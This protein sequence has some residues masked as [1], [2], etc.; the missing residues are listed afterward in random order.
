MRVLSLLLLTIATPSLAVPLEINHQ[1]RLHDALGV[2]LDGSHDLTV[3]IYDTATGGS[4]AWTE[5]HTGVA[6]DNGY[7]TLQV[8][9]VSALDDTL[10]DGNTLYLSLQV[11]AGAEL[12]PRLPLVSVPY[13]IR[14]ETATVAD[15]AGS[16]SWSDV[17]GVPAG[18]DDGQ[19][20]D[21]LAE[22]VP[23][24]SDGEVATFAS[25]AWTCA[26]V[27]AADPNHALDADNIGSGIVNVSYLPIGTSAS[28]VA[29]G[30]HVHADYLPTANLGAAVD[31][32]LANNPVTLHAGTTVGG[33][34]IS[35]VG[36][37][38][39]PQTQSGNFT[40]SAS[41]D[42]AWFAITGDADVAL[43]D[44]AG[45]SAGFVVAFK[46]VSGSAIALNANSGQT[47]D[48]ATTLSLALPGSGLALITDGTDW[49][50]LFGSGDAYI[51]GQGWF[52]G[53][54]YTDSPG[55]YG[56]CPSTIT[57]DRMNDGVYGGANGWGSPQSG[58]GQYLQ[59]DLGTFRWISMIRLGGG[60]MPCWGNAHNYQNGREIQTSP[61][62]SNWTTLFAISGAQAGATDFNFA[63]VQ[64]RYVRL[65]TVA[66]SWAAT[67]EFRVGN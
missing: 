43:P 13:A 25:G 42:Y 40:V 5:Q 38:W 41:D 10:F 28:H 1:G 62:G 52:A 60:N 4:A 6:L 31:N 55:T 30:D 44:T 34:P 45:L 48:G 61:D 57:Y 20:N 35:D 33:T 21:T 11:D 49:Y 26:A 37:R 53:I 17:S 56:S 32:H 14:A 23:N 18:L 47:I 67:T 19:D 65:V 24:C 39:I 51:L 58:L 9:A 27:P 54:T 3:R 29:A 66:S 59:A 36:G 15:S 64:A 22:L 2:P 50:T 16:V 7:Y 8:G 63:P 46:N 12:S